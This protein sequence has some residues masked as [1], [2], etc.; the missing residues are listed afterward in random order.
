[1]TARGRLSSQEV[2]TPSEDGF[3]ANLITV[4]DPEFAARSTDVLRAKQPG[5]PFVSF[6]ADH[7]IVSSAEHPILAVWTFPRGD[8]DQSDHR[9]FRVCLPLYGVSRTTST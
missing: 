6:L 3:L 7:T 2:Q 9:P 5:G 4:N 8:D 1:M